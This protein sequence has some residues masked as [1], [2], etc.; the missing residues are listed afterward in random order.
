MP[1]YTKITIMAH[2]KLF[3]QVLE[4]I[5]MTQ[6]TNQFQYVHLARINLY[7]IGLPWKRI[8][9]HI[10]DLQASDQEERLRRNRLQTV[11]EVVQLALLNR[12]MKRTDLITEAF[13]STLLLL[14]HIDEFVGLAHV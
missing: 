12:S 9:Y 13:G 6:N 5:L 8:N 3:E 14:D 2:L 4:Q 1:V 11:L 7:V 10:C